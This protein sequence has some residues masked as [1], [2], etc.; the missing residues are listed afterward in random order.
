MNTTNHLTS[1]RVRVNLET[2]GFAVGCNPS[3]RKKSSYPI[4]STSTQHIA[5]PQCILPFP[6]ILHFVLYQKRLHVA[7]EMST[8]ST[9][10]RAR[11]QSSATRDSSTVAET[12]YAFE[13]SFSSP[14]RSS[15]DALERGWSNSCRC[16]K[17]GGVN[18]DSR[19]LA[20]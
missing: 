14:S 10:F 8:I 6:L 11:K 9:G 4:C 7:Y 5:W 20:R 13:P 15:V 1:R 18:P 12:G 16:G 17:D 3:G 2:T 19:H